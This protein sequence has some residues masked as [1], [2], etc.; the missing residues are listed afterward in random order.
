MFVYIIYERVY[1]HMGMWVYTCTYV[2]FCINE[3]KREWLQGKKSGEFE[4]DGK[5][6]IVD[7]FSISLGIEYVTPSQKAPK[8]SEHF[9]LT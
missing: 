1:E 3:Y 5:R 4:D 9:S 7:A 6:E 8:G 2:C